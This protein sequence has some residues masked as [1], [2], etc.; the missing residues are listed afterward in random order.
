MIAE[1]RTG[2]LYVN[3]NIYCLYNNTNI[4]NNV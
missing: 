2:K 3:S 4:D 1:G